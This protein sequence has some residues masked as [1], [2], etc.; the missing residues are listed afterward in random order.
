[1]SWGMRDKMMRSKQYELFEREET[2]LDY[3]FVRKD[4][5]LFS[6][7]LPDESVKLIIT[8][9]PYNIGKSYETKTGIDEGHE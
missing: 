6:K 8:S 7:S 2:A 1:M 5:R 4:A 9:P 3:E